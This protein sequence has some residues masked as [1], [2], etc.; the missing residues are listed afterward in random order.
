MSD[1]I[2]WGIAAAFLLMGVVALIRPEHVTSY[3]SL[4]QIPRDMRNEVRAVYGGFGLAIA[5]LLAA[6]VNSPVL[7]P[8]IVLTVG[9]ALLGMAGGRLLSLIW[10]RPLGRYPTLF[11]MIEVFAGGALLWVFSSLPA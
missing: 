7:T 5:S 8:G 11:L 3:F 9:V 4:T 1:V 10:D 2:L 6:A